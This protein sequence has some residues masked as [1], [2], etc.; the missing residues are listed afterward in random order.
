MSI[1]V[2]EKNTTTQLSLDTNLP[3]YWVRER[4]QLFVDLLNLWHSLSHGSQILQLEKAALELGCN[5][6]LIFMEPEGVVRH[7]FFSFINPCDSSCPYLWHHCIAAERMS[8]NERTWDHKGWSPFWISTICYHTEMQLK[9]WLK[10]YLGT[11]CFLLSLF[12]SGYCMSFSSSI[13]LQPWFVYGAS[14]CGWVKTTIW[15]SPPC[16]YSSCA[17]KSFFLTTSPFLNH[18]PCLWC[19]IT[20]SLLLKSRCLPKSNLHFLVWRLISTRL[21]HTHCVLV[22]H[23]KVFIVWAP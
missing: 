5:Y 8:F 18:N 21:S 9:N 17:S 3:G 22:E 14:S 10:T 15:I 11:V 13:S 12:P 7:N 2:I 23:G 19:R 20:T 1:R 16:N 4:R 6:T